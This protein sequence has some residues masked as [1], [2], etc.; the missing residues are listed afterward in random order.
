MMELAQSLVAQAK[1][2]QSYIEAYGDC[3]RIRET[4]SSVPDISSVAPSP[5]ADTFLDMDTFSPSAN[6]TLNLIRNMH[7]MP[8]PF[9][10]YSESQ[11]CQCCF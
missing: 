2:L 7:N 8:S 3:D 4:R 11:Y 9:A 10:T 1:E 5:A 6:S